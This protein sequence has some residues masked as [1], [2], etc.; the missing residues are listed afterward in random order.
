MFSDH[1]QESPNHADHSGKPISGAKSTVYKHQL[2]QAAI[3]IAACV[4]H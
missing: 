2:Q 1:G 4:K 3:F